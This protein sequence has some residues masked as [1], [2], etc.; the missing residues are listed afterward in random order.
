MPVCALSWWT[1]GTQDGLIVFFPVLENLYPANTWA[2]ISRY[3][4]HPS[5]LSPLYPSSQH[6]QVICKGCAL[7]CVIAI[8]NQTL[9]IRCPG[10]T[11]R[12]LSSSTTHPWPTLPDF[13]YGFITQVRSLPGP[14]SSRFLVVLYPL[15]IWFSGIQFSLSD[16]FQSNCSSSKLGNLI[17]SCA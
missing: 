17:S 11:N 9:D 5:S 3:I 13:I 14:A 8:Y 16:S 12:F 15:S 6:H 2:S 7:C 4:S 1:V 10:G